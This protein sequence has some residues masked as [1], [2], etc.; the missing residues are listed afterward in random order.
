MSKSLPRSTG[1]KSQSGSHCIKKGKEYGSPGSWRRETNPSYLAQVEGKLKDHPTYR[2]SSRAEIQKLAKKLTD[3]EEME[4]YFREMPQLQIADYGVVKLSDVSVSIKQDDDPGGELEL[5]DTVEQP[6]TNEQPAA[7]AVA[8][9]ATSI[10]TSQAAAA[11]ITSHVDLLSSLSCRVKDLTSFPVRL[12]LFPLPQDNMVGRNS[13]ASM[14][15]KKFGP[16]LASL[17]IGNTML[18]WT[19]HH[20]VIPHYKIPE[21]PALITNF[22]EM[23]SQLQDQAKQRR[24]RSGSVVGQVDLMLEVS[25]SVYDVIKTII[26]VIVTWN[27]FN[28]YNISSRNSQ[29]FAQH[30][31]KMLGITDIPLSGLALNALQEKLRNDVQSTTR[32]VFGNHAFLDDYVRQRIHELRTRE[33]EYLLTEYY[34][35]HLQAREGHAGA[36]SWTCEEPNCRMQSLEQNINGEENELLLTSLHQS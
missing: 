3:P 16:M 35:F 9:A 34:R 20:L 18:E 11:P 15:E 6:D 2:E 19:P 36:E 33:M 10:N 12:Y 32:T 28:Y 7:A 1:S 13:Y 26:K 22:T 5:T 25:K 23:A 29:D 17:Q 4:E 14:L 8:A 27:R 21:Q 31:M 30:V 24:A